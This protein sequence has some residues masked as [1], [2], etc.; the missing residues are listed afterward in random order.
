MGL[1]NPTID[2][3]SSI[4]KNEYQFIKKKISTFYENILLPFSKT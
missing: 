1:E 3:F 2:S 4:K